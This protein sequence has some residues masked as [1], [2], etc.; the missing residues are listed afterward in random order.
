MTVVR[1]HSKIRPVAASAPGPEIIAVHIPKTA[2]AAF[3]L[4]LESVYGKQQVENDKPRT[5]RE[6][7]DID[8]DTWNRET[9]AA[10]A[11]RQSW[12]KVITGHF[13]LGKYEA[14]R[15]SAYTIVWLREPAARL[16]SLY[17]YLRTIPALINPSSLSPKMIP[18]K[19]IMDFEW[20]S[21]PM[22]R[23]FL[24]GY[25]LD[26]FDFVGIQ[27]H[28]AEDV[29]EL[30]RTLGWPSVDVPMHNRTATPEY[31]D[32]RPS[33]ELLQKIRSVNEEDIEL[34]ERA[35]ERR[36]ARVGVRASL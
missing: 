17:F 29:A 36:R 27:E 9:G 8:F 25:D 15:R 10:L 18:V 7:Q 24:R 14:Y 22:S 21:N 23:R 32:F 12:P 16:I 11:G 28:F 13:W 20:P 3:N 33:A 26:D 19:D 1:V 2:G 35:L 6:P 4:V 30:G 31:R 5:F 34:Y